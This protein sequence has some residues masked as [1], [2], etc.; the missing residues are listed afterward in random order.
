MHR[1]FQSRNLMVADG[2]IRIIDFQGVRCQPA[3]L[4]DGVD[5]VLVEKILVEE[6]VVDVAVPVDA[7]DRKPRP[8]A[9]AERNVQHAR[10]IQPVV[11][12]DP[13]FQ[14]ALEPLD[15]AVGGENQRAARR[16]LAE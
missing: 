13:A 14:R 9:V 11:V 7:G 16:I 12:T 8:Q 4:G 1:D 10:D 15:R 5:T 2:E 6:L 3:E